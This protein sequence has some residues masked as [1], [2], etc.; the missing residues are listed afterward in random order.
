MK[1]FLDVFEAG[2]SRF[3]PDPT[4]GYENNRQYV[5]DQRFLAAL[6]G[7]IAIGLPLVM[8]LGAAIGPCFYVSISH[9]YYA[10]FFGDIFVVA[11]AVIGTFLVAYR[12]AS[13]RE[14]R[15]ATY[16]GLFAFGIGLFPTTGRGCDATEFSHRVLL[17]PKALSPSDQGLLIL[18]ENIDRLFEL[19]KHVGVLHYISA[20]FLFLFLAYYSFYVFTRVVPGQ[21]RT[22]DGTLSPVKR[23]RNR[24]YRWSGI[25]IVLCIV[26]MAANAFFKWPWWDGLHATFWC[27]TF[28][29][30]AFGVA[31]MVKGRFWGWYLL[32]ED[33]ATAS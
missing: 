33:E 13:P 26:A 6:V 29:L 32:D 27:E 31:W 19:F 22:Q 11:L 5:I 15:L 3:Q 7:T 23:T 14:S 8:L 4:Y 30:W 24:F 12:G 2:E 9:F 17:G 18:T 10:Q 25:I 20:A 28:A 16:A 1:H 21:H